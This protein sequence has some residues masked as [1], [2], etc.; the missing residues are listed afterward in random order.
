MLRTLLTLLVLLV[1]SVAQ[2]CPVCDSETAQQLR[3]ELRGEALGI[4]VVA[5]ASP[6]IVT[7]GLVAAIHFVTGGGGRRP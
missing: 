3:A 1:P 7:V 6:F 2:A 4:S 5:I